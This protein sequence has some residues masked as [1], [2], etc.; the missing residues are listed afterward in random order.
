VVTP[1]MWQTYCNEVLTRNKT[2][3]K[4]IA[5][6]QELVDTMLTR[7]KPGESAAR[8]VENTEPLIGDTGNLDIENRPVMSPPPAGR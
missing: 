1:P 8:K 6:H 5:N 3:L 2:V 4:R 7:V